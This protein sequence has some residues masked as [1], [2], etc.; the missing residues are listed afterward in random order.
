MDNHNENEQEMEGI[1]DGDDE[2]V[3]ANVFNVS[4][5]ETIGTVSRAAR[6][7]REVFN[8]PVS[9][10]HLRFSVAICRNC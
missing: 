4:Y 2:E 8:S 9:H 6:E 1:H 7:N 3:V 10:L 5:P